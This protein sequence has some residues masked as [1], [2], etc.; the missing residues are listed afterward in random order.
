MEILNS[1]SL[2]ENYNPTIEPLDVNVFKTVEKDGLV[3]RHLY[4]TGRRLNE[5]KATRVYGVVCFKNTKPAKQAV[6]YVGDYKQPVNLDELEQLARQGF[7]AMSIDF[8]GQS[9]KGVYTVYPDELKYCNEIYA[10]DMF[11]VQTT[12]KETKMYEYALNCLRAI[13]YLESEQKSKG[14]S[15]VTQGRGAFVGV[16][17]MGV[18]TRL[19]NGA[20]LFGALSC[21]F[22]EDEASEMVDPSDAESLKHHLEYDIRRQSWT[23][24]LAPQTYAL[25]IKIPVYVVNSA[26]SSYVDIEQVN[27]TNARM[28][29]NCRFLTLP[30][31]LDYI[32]DKY[33]DS[34]VRWLKGAQAPLPQQL[35]SSVDANGD[36]CI[37]VQTSSSINK[38]SVWY[39]SNAKGRARYWRSARLSRDGDYYVAK[40]DLYDKENDIIAFGMAD[41]EVATATPLFYD[42]VS[43][44]RPKIVNK[45]IFSGN[46]S[47]T[48]ATTQ[49]R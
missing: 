28:N 9:S 40:L 20:V 36:Y 41:R 16:I 24:G 34:L 44:A 35:T 15:L 26:N 49:S 6:L 4:F 14:V 43:V 5:N 8:A 32:T 1:K 39:C 48:L 10:T 30:N 38:T 25:Q 2:W 17:A 11:D 46:R 45:N 31:A 22:P 3:T 23:L 13:T 42:K 37:K 33:F 21:R 18:D 12:A 47:L 27:K 19:T 29:K 7:I